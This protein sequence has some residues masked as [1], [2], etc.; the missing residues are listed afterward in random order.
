VATLTDKTIEL[1]RLTFHY[2]E[3]GDPGAPPLILLHGLMYDARDWDE[4]AHFL[5]EYFHVFALTQR[6]HGE[7]ARAANYSF[8]LMCDDLEQF[9]NA[10]ALKR[11]TLDRTSATLSG[12]NL[13]DRMVLGFAM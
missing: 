9:A 12:Q 5:A 13:H 2:R 1:S 10:L 7:S 3:A 6:G 8:E 11:F 4:I